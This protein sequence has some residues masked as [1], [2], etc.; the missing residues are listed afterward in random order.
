MPFLLSKHS[1]NTL[2]RL[3]SSPDKERNTGFY[4]LR[5]TYTKNGISLTRQG[6]EQFFSS[7]NPTRSRTFCDSLQESVHLSISTACSVCRTVLWIFL[8][9]SAV[10]FFWWRHTALLR[11]LSSFSLSS[12]HTFRFAKSNYLEI[13]YCFFLGGS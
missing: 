5:T 13:F 11:I 10:F 8:P 7:K 12:F 3:N 9:F 1:K 6:R 4:S 2:K